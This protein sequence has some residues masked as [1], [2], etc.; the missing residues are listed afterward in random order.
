MGAEAGKLVGEQAVKLK[1]EAEKFVNCTH[2]Q[3]RPTKTSAEAPIIESAPEVTAVGYNIGDRVVCLGTAFGRYEKGQVGTICQV[4]D[5]QT[6]LVLL[7]GREKPLA[8]GQACFEHADGIEWEMAGKVKR[9]THLPSSVKRS[10]ELEDLI[11]QLFRKQ[12]L[13]GN[14]VLEEEELIKLNQKI[15]YLHHGKDHRKQASTKE[16]MTKLF[17]ERLDVRGKAIVYPLFRE[18]ILHQLDDV[19][20]DER[21]QVIIVEQW[22]AEACAGR[23]IFAVCSISSESDAMFMPRSQLKDELPSPAL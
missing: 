13:N 4:D 9:G 6:A 14:G 11:Q 16:N 5:T 21:A 17:R 7:D 3:R 8:I 15:A 12:D 18:Y 23:E 20:T 19:D 22:I 1:E 2:K 10:D